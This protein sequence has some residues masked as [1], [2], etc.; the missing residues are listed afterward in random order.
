MQGNIVKMNPLPLIG[1]ANILDG[2]L[3]FQKLLLT[4]YI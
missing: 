2:L 3:L 1:Y 4:W